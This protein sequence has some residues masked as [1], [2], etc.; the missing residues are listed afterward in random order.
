MSK[1]KEIASVEKHPRISRISRFLFRP[2][3]QRVLHL[4]S[5][6]WL[7]NDSPPLDNRQLLKYDVYTDNSQW[8]NEA[9]SIATLIEDGHE[10]WFGYH[11]EWKWHMRRSD[12]NKMI[13][14][15]LFVQVWHNWFGLR[16]W[17]Y[18]KAL[19][20]VVNKQQRLI[21]RIR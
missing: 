19:H 1:T 21:G 5:Q 2:F 7:G 10:V 15:Y 6:E 3:W 17:L 12:F 13:L 14:R 11:N 16:N 8:D 18:F 20:K 4:T 9:Y